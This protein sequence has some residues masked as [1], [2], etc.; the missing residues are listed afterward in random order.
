[1]GYKSI[2]SESE[3]IR[4]SGSAKGTNLTHHYLGTEG[5]AIAQENSEISSSYACLQC[6][7]RVTILSILNSRRSS[8]KLPQPTVFHV[9]WAG[10]WE[11]FSTSN[12]HA[13]VEPHRL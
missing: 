9:D 4:G 6:E 11:K 10:Y 8:Q 12:S 2:F 5:A 7:S 1:M 3:R 13:S